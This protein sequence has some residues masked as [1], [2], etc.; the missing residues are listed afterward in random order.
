MYKVYGFPERGAKS[1]METANIEIAKDI[2]ELLRAKGM[3]VRIYAQDRKKNGDV[4]ETLI[5]SAR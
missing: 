5:E 1:V 3:T 4:V 2:A